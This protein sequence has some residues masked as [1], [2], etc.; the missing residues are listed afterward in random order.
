[1]T[2]SLYLLNVSMIWL[3]SILFFDTVLQK[4]TFHKANRVFLL[5]TLL[6]G[7][8]IPLLSFETSETT[9]PESYRDA[10]YK[11]ENFKQAINESGKV[12]KRNGFTWDMHTLLL[13]IYIAGVLISIAFVLK[14]IIEVTRFYRLGKKHGF[15]HYVLIETGK[16]H[17]PFSI[18]NN[19][20]VSSI[21]SYTDAELAMIISHELRHTFFMHI[22]DKLILTIVR[23]AFW[24]HPLVYLYQRKLLMLHEYQADQTGKNNEAAYGGFL[25]EQSLLRGHSLVTY[26]FNY[27]PIKNR[28]AML[29]KNKSPKIRL[30]KYVLFVPLM[31][32]VSLLFN[33]NVKSQNN[34][35]TD[36]SDSAR[37][38]L[39]Y[40]V[41]GN[42]F[43]MNPGI[44]DSIQVM[45]PAT[46]Q[47]IMYAHHEEPYPL[48]INGEKIYQE[49]LDKN[50]KFKNSNE[51]VDEFI[52]NKILKQLINK[53]VNHKFRA[54]INYVISKNGKVVFCDVFIDQSVKIDD[55]AKIDIEKKIKSV[56][57]DEMEFE[58]A[59]LN[60]NTAN[61]LLSTSISLY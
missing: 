56:C 38:N 57:Y 23:T 28:I 40:V 25:I 55:K 2:L 21:K 53:G 10:V 1:M 52:T 29:T 6:A 46:G 42:T 41:R 8:F 47:T 24:F 32:V 45:D 15:G 4:E 17:S 51:S 48:K 58:P 36:E 61:S 54:T 37:F 50:A 27:S 26:S 49:G 20:F 60:G 12:I 34:I 39:Q 19:I 44:T 11:I 43:D 31:I 30:T 59:T 16:E 22:I 35:I 13:V 3:V 33:N 18:S 7:I 14:E 9:Y 5:V